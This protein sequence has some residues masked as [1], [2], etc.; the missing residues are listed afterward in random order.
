[1]FTVWA[2]KQIMMSYKINTSWRFLRKHLLSK[3]R[4]Y[5]EHTITF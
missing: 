3:R 4:L 5:S 2:C 1:M